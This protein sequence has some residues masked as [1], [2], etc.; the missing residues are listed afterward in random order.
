MKMSRQE[1]AELIWAI[2]TGRTQPLIYGDLAA[3]MGYKRRAGRSLGPALDIV[4]RCCRCHGFPRLTVT[5]RRQNTGLPTPG[6][7]EEYPPYSE[8]QVG[9][10]QEEVFDYDWPEAMPADGLS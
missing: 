1:Q 5:V 6:W 10:Y 4:R 3:E 7:D 2:L 9:Q 8:D